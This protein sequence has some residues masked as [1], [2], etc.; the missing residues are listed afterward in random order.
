MCLAAETEGSLRKVFRITQTYGV[1]LGPESR[2]GKKG[3]ARLQTISTRHEGGQS[4]AVEKDFT[5]YSQSKPPL[6]L[7]M[8]GRR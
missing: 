4:H 2:L 8:D 6:K 7:F 3:E 1:S 5:E